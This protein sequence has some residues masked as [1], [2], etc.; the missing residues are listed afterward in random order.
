PAS[1]YFAQGVV[2]NRW[3][4]MMG[5]AFS[6]VFR[7]I[8]VGLMVSACATGPTDAPP[9]PDAEPELAGD[10]QIPD[11]EEEP[12]VA[13]APSPKPDVDLPADFVFP[14]SLSLCPRMTI[15]NAPPA[16]SDGEITGYQTMATINGTQIAV[17]PVEA[18]CFS[19]GFGPRNGRPHKG[20]DLNHPDPVT[21][22]AAGN[23]WVREKIYRDD[24]GNMLVI[25]HGDT[26][27]TRYAHLE[28]FADFVEVGDRVTSGQPIGIM[29]K[30]GDTTVARHLHYEVLTGDWGVLT[31]SFGLTPVDIF[32][33][34]PTN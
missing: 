14:K 34:I 2:W 6:N 27:F 25:Q 30:T 1:A 9:I 32:A 15:S 19:S 4:I 17:A 28:S 12:I 18:G 31:G 13:P 8:V 5:Q 33:H 20:I 23:G 16:N 3:R 7:L 24:Y 26:V 11:A 22:F 10:A 21:V 29:G